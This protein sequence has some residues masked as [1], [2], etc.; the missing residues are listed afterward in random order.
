MEVVFATIPEGKEGCLW[1]KAREEIS[2]GEV[3]AS[4]GVIYRTFLVRRQFLY[5]KPQRATWNTGGAGHRGSEATSPQ[6]LVLSP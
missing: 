5:G 1:I 2:S 3:A 6:S 4:L